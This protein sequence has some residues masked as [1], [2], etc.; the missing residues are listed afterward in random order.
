MKQFWMM[1]WSKLQVGGILT[2]HICHFL[3]YK[4]DL[5]WAFFQLW[6]SWEVEIKHKYPT[7]SP[8]S[9]LLLSRYTSWSASLTSSLRTCAYSAEFNSVHSLSR[10]RLS[11]TPWTGAYQAS[12]SITSSQSLLKLCPLSWWCHPTISSSYHPLLLLSSFFPSIRVFSN[13][14]VLPISWPMYWSFSFSI[15]PSSE[16]SRLI[17][18]RMDWFGFLA[19]QGLSRVFSNT[20]VQ[21]HQFFSAQLSL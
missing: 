10:V 15:R 19:V 7:P 12:I 5:S 16:H 2:L 3:S 21:K 8:V 14:S 6:R 4:V 17:S 20:T 13:E 11:V 1:M 18:F 9:H